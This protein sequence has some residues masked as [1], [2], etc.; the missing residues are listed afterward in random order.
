MAMMEAIWRCPQ[1]EQI[2]HL[3][4][5]CPECGARPSI[6]K[7]LRVIIRRQRLVSVGPAVMIYRRGEGV[8]ELEGTLDLRTMDALRGAGGVGYWS[9][10]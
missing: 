1:F 8:E 5:T 3:W 7:E 10:Q 4:N 2:V 9:G 6:K